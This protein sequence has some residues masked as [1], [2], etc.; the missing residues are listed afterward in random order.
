MTFVF[1]VFADGTVLACLR[2]ICRQVRN[3]HFDIISLVVA[4]MVLQEA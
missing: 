1:G 2:L 4:K 3:E